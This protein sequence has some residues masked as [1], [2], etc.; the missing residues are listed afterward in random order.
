[1][2]GYYIVKTAGVAELFRNLNSACLN[3]APCRRRL[4]SIPSPSAELH[5]G[6]ERIV[7]LIF[8]YKENFAEICFFPSFLKDALWIIM[9]VKLALR[10][11]FLRAGYRTS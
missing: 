7:L 5:K 11:L 4:C 1:M 8:C 2:I 6:F 9:L 10:N 3:P